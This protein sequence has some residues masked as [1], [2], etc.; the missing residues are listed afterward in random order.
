MREVSAEFNMETAPA[1]NSLAGKGFFSEGPC[2][3]SIS[4][5]LEE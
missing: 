1:I 4:Q 3:A 2:E 5:D